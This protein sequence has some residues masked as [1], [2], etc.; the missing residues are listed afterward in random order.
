MMAALFA[1]AT[2]SLL[3]AV[4]CGTYTVTDEAWFEVEIKDYDGP[5]QDFRGRFTVALFGET[6]PMTA[7]N[8]AAIARGYQR[9]KVSKK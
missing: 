9:G 8:F 3:V 6:A 4:H 2:L 5:G 7:M 1:F